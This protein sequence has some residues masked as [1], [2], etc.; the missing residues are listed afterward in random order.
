MNVILDNPT[1]EEKNI[2]ISSSISPDTFYDGKQIQ[3]YAIA[4]YMVDHYHII[5][6]FDML[7]MYD[8]GIY[9]NDIDMI[10]RLIV[11]LAPKIKPS[12]IKSVLEALMFNAPNSYESDHK[13]IAFNNCIVNI[14]NLEPIEFAPKYIITNRIN[15]YYDHNILNSNNANVEY[16][17]S[18][19]KTLSCSDSQLE[20]LYLEIL[21]YSM[22]KSYKFQLGFILKGKPNDGKSTFLKLVEA[23]L[24]SHCSHLNL[25]QLSNLKSLRSLYNCTANIIDDVN[26]I[27]KINLAQ[28][29]SIVTGGTI[30]ISDK[31]GQSF[32]FEPYTTLLIGTTNI[33]NFKNFNQSLT[34]RFKIIPFNAN[35]DTNAVHGTE[36]VIR[37][38]DNLN[39][40]AVM[41]LQA[42]HNVLQDKHFHISEAIERDT[43]S[44]FLDSNSD[45]DFILSHPINMIMSKSEYYSA[46][47]VWCNHV[48]KIA[49]SNVSFGKTALALGYLPD[50]LS[51]DG[52]RDTYYKASDFNMN[53]LKADY[54]IYCQ[55]ATDT[56]TPLTFSQYVYSLNANLGNK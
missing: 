20:N 18:Y 39:I 6:L 32:T 29:Q 13:Y 37:Q 34:R 35:F 2:D 40:I 11:R 41:A 56:E 8:N 15:A 54:D 27:G 16:V 42:F 36:D 55:S 10:K 4:D 23:L 33:L 7:Y 26:E 50:R 12:A 46:Y 53:K 44:Y 21:G 24:G 5:K 25:E 52:V 45:M 31:K 14:E 48:N 22:V 1:N 28:I 19:L 47:C 17:K 38:Q 43:M 51:I 9:V 49:V 3:P 30:S